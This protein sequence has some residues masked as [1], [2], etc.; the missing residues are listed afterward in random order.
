MAALR[1][2]CLVP[3]R[4]SAGRCKVF[5]RPDRCA[6]QDVTVSAFDDAMT[7]DLQDRKVHHPIAPRPVPAPPLFLPVAHVSIQSASAALTVRICTRLLRP[8]FGD[9]RHRLEAAGDPISGELPELP[10]A[11][12]EAP[13]PYV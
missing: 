5:R 12:A 8:G 6:G 2:G 13:A 11:H 9:L 10:G 3:H 4:P 1:V 7:A